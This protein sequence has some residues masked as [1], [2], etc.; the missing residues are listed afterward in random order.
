MASVEVDGSRLVARAEEEGVHG[1]VLEGSLKFDPRPDGVAVVLELTSVGPDSDWTPAVKDLISRT[2][3]PGPLV[4][5]HGQ[6]ETETWQ[7]NAR[8]VNTLKRLPRLRS[9]HERS[10]G[11]PR[12]VQ[13]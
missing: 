9:I 12:L 8:R 11:G 2:L 5:R 3:L 7:H 13:S 6:T 4:I 1:V 10:L